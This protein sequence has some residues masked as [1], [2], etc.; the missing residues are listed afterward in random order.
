MRLTWVK[1][2]TYNLFSVT[3]IIITVCIVEQD[4]KIKC[5]QL[6][7]L[8]W[9]ILRQSKAPS[10]AAL[11]RITVLLPINMLVWHERLVDL[12]VDPSG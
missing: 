8:I 1:V 4:C 10:I 6:N 3:I 5:Y 2:S 9:I 12:T 11:L 7:I